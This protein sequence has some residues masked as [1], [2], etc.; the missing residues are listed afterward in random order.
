MSVY[1][2]C[3][4]LQNIQKT[5]KIEGFGAQFGMQHKNLII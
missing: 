1:L 2:N 3:E 5:I 4:F